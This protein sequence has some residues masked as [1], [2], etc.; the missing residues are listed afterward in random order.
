MEL[1]VLSGGG[2]FSPDARF[3]SGV[4]ILFEANNGAEEED[5]P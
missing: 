2:I 5:N 3:M 1:R 4:N